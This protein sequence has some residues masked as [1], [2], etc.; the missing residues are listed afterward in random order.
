MITLDSWLNMLPHDGTEHLKSCWTPKVTVRQLTSGQ[1]DAFSQRCYLT[2]LCF[3]ESI[4]SLTELYQLHLYMFVMIEVLNVINLSIKQLDCELE[5]SFALWWRRAQPI[6]C[7]WTCDK[8]QLQD[9]QLKW[10]R[11]ISFPICPNLT[12]LSY[13]CGAFK[14]HYWKNSFK[15]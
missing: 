5:I 10:S 6:L 1:W 9:V 15:F 13:G 12:F 3:L 2:V 11:F 14:K 7:C 8:N 4:V